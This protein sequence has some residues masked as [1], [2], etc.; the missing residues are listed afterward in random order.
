MHGRTLYH[1][2]FTVW[3]IT[4][5]SAG[6]HDKPG[7][8]R[9]LGGEGRPTGIHRPAEEDADTRRRQTDHTH[10]DTE[11][12]F[13]YHDAPA[14]LPSQL[15]V[16]QQLCGLMIICSD[17]VPMIPLID[18][19]TDWLS[20]FVFA[21][22]AAWSPASRIWTFANADA[23][24]SRMEKICL[25]ATIPRVQPPTSQSPSAANWTSTIRWVW[26]STL[27]LPQGNFCSI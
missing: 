8:D 9:H 17:C 25:P 27:N 16:S 15:T 14:A 6:E 5:P 10:E 7:G 21:H 1:C 2:A 18:W 24:P 11:S 19:L 20:S 3:L 23:A 4:R 12:P 22:V 13:C 26:I